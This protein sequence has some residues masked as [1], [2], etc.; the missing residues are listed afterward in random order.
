MIVLSGNI[1]SIAYLRLL[2]V[3]TDGFCDVTPSRVGDTFDLGCVCVELDHGQRLFPIPS[4]ALNPAFALVEACW[5]V[6]GR[7]DLSTLQDILPHYGIFSDD[8]HT[9]N[10]AY[11]HRM[12]TFFGIDQINAVI[13]TLRRDPYSRRQVI[14]LY[15]P[16]DLTKA[17]KDI[18][19]N[20]QMIVR[21]AEDRLEI[22]VINRSNDL[23]LGVPYN[24]FVFS[25][26]QELIARELN[27]KP[28]IQRH[29]STGMHLYCKDADSARNLLKN[30]AESDLHLVEDSVSGFDYGSLLESAEEI[31]VGSYGK[32]KDKNLQAFFSLY[33][34]YRK[35]RRSG[36]RVIE[37]CE[38]S[39][40]LQLMLAQWISAFQPNRKAGP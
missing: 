7:N 32:I 11:G 15:A 40:L 29:F 12:K 25:V 30:T 22:T 39:D 9:L 6:C 36:Q 27:I 24:W 21:I 34:E 1:P 16:S 14:S 31:S 37:K 38:S 20:T 13:D 8:E 18:P 17:S 3:A 4:R 35:K 23:W 26:I 5:V 2:E 33:D 10:G 28:G 19:C